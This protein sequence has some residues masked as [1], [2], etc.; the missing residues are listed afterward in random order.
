MHGPAFLHSFSTP[1]D[2]KGDVVH[3]GECACIAA[4]HV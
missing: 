4:W 2:Q 1:S 3:I